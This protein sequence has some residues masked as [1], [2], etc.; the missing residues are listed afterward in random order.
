MSL[1]KIAKATRLSVATVSRALRNDSSVTA[2]TAARVREAARRLGYKFNPYVGALMSS[3]RRSQGQAFR[4]NLAL[5]W[6]DLSPRHPSHEEMLPIQAA[7]RKRA[8]ELGYVLDEF[9]L[10]DHRPAK[11]L[12]ILK[13][14]NIQGILFSPSYNPFGRIRLRFPLDGFAAVGLGWAITHPTLYNVRLDQYQAMALAMHHAR[15]GFKKRGIAALCDSS[16]LRRSSYVMRASFLVSHPAGPAVAASLFLESRHLK[17]ES[18]VALFRR[19]D[20]QTLIM[21]RDSDYPPWLD[22]VIPP[23]N[24]IY[25]EKPRPSGQCQG[26][27]DRR[28]FLVGQW[29]IET[30]IGLIQ[31]GEKG[32]PETPQVLLVPPRW[33]AR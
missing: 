6:V 25:L 4:G 21:Q 29:G 2:A 14:R 20:V 24:R 22:A 19:H 1:R 8:R 9:R 13:S 17:K 5:I 7:A 16:G 12:Q 3:L 30:L 18:V 27:I 32:I 23:T 33:V 28:Y 15:H 26:W 31:R 11:L 10:K